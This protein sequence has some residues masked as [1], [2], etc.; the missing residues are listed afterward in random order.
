M[1]DEIIIKPKEIVA[2][3]EKAGKLVF[4]KGA[5]EAL[6]KLLEWQNKINEIVTQVAFKIEEAGISLSPDFKGVLG[7]KT[8]AV[9]RLYGDKYTYDKS[10]R[11]IVKPYLKTITFY[12]PDSELVENYK[13]NK[14]KLPD[15]IIEKEREPKLKLSLIEE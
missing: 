1:D 11:D 8:K 4:D 14:G 6:A 3:S 7:G 10:R 5:D 2:L 9:R 15:G 12:K 13:E